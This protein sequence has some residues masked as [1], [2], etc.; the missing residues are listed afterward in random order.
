MP[1]LDKR[2]CGIPSRLCDDMC[3]AD[4]LQRESRNRIREGH[5][6]YQL[7]YCPYLKKFILYGNRRDIVIN[8]FRENVDE[9]E[10]KSYSC[11]CPL[12]QHKVALQ[13]FQMHSGEFFAEG[14]P[15][16]VEQ[17]RD[18]GAA[19]HAFGTDI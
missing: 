15:D 7:V 4:H 16:Q 18:A 9:Q 11:R 10:S 14:L 19:G 2:R 5:T 1:A 6:H 3:C 12:L 8:Y 17:F 13:I